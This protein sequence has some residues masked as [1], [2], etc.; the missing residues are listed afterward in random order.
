[1]TTSRTP[2]SL[3]E[4]QETVLTLL[5]QRARP[6]DVVWTD[7][8]APLDLFGAAADD[9]EAPGPGS[10]P[11]RSLP[12]ASLPPALLKL[13]AHVM[14]HRDH[15]RW[16]VLYRVAWRT[17][18]DENLLGNPLDPDVRRLETWAAQVRRDVHKMHAFVRFRKVD[19]PGGP[20]YVA[21]YRPDHLILPLVRR[22]FVERFG[23]MRW[24]ILTPD[25]SLHWDGERCIMGP[26]A[27]R[28]AAPDGDELERLWRTYY[29]AIFNPARTNLKAMRREMPQRHWDLLP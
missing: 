20:T 3:K 12:S 6:A 28:T 7:D 5:A 8:T 19:A 1:M 15:A 9:T 25:G 26:A 22:F 13:A 18:T 2:R 17:A 10:R 4:W 27:A 14:R 23:S 16:L 21:W 24:S 29:G 11:P